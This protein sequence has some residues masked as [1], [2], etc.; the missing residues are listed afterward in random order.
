MCTGKKK[1]SPDN[2]L[3]SYNG[4]RQIKKDTRERS[5]QL[6]RVNSYT[7]NVRDS[8]IPSVCMFVCWLS[9]SE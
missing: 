9:F 5:K 6:T 1:K 7:R 8:F 4:L 3:M 2:F